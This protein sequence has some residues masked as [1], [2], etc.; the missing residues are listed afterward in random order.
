MVDDPEVR[1][2]RLRLLGEIAD[3][4]N[5]IAHFHQ[6]ATQLQGREPTVSA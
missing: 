3:V 1:E 4:V 5:G 2:N 6:L